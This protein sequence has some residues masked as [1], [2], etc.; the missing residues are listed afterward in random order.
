MYLCFKWN[1]YVLNETNNINTLEMATGRAASGP[2]RAWK[3][4]P[5]GLTGPNGPKN[6]FILKFSV[7]RKIEIFVNVLQILLKIFKTSKFFLKVCQK[8]Q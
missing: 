3:S 7:Q 5:A 6:V 4:R 8:C 1:I 2:G